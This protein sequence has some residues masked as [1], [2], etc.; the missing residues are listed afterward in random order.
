MDSEAYKIESICQL[1]DSETYTRLKGD[2]TQ[3][4]MKELSSLLDGGVK[5]GIFSSKRSAYLLGCVLD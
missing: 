1:S 5:V 2:P 3:S 4:F